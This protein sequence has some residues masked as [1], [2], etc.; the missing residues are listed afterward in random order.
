MV[1]RSLIGSHIGRT[2]GT[3]FTGPQRRN[4][5]GMTAMVSRRGLL[6]A[7]AA[8]SGVLAASPALAGPAAEQ[9]LNKLMERLW[10]EQLHRFPELATRCGA[11][12]GAQ[13]ALRGRLGPWSRAGR[14]DWVGWARSAVRRIA[15]IDATALPQAAALNRGVLLDLFSKIVAMGER[16]RFGAG[17]GDI[18]APVGPYALSP[19]AGPGQVL[20]L[21]LYAD[22]PIATTTDCEAWL[23][24]LSAVPGALDAATEAFRGDVAAGVVPPQFALDATIAQLRRL[25]G[26]DPANGPFVA[27]PA[28]RAAAA[29]LAPKWAGRAAMIVARAIGP[30]VDRQLAALAATREVAGTEAG[31]WALPQGEQFYADALA[32]HTGTALSPADVHTAGLEQVERTNAEL[33]AALAGIG[34]AS[35]TVT[36]RLAVLGENAA[37]R[38]AGGTAGQE[39][40]LATVAV[41]LRRL[42]QHLPEW[43]PILPDTPL[44]ARSMPEGYGLDQPLLAASGDGS[45]TSGSGSLLVDLGT[46]ARWPRFAIPS[47][48][49]RSAVGAGWDTAMARAS[50]DAPAIRAGGTRY[51]AFGAGWAL[52]SEQV[53]DEQ[54]YYAASPGGRIGYLQAQLL[55]AARLVADTGLHTRRW[56]HERTVSYLVE[57]T[58]LSP[59]DARAEAQRCA[60]APGEACAAA[61]GQAE[62]HRLRALARRLAGTGFDPDRFHRLIRYGPMPFGVLEDLVT[63]TFTR[64]MSVLAMRTA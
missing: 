21:L 5:S 63:T 45:F 24:R 38:F 12:T 64:R 9:Q 61:V 2:Q 42:R 26:T 8:L 51:D 23:A 49:F 54:G 30:A 19:L 62:W 11:D 53:A 16:H 13:A 22:Q 34:P 58:G 17:P 60:I 44:D 52:Y 50:A 31:A 28:A 29:G 7:A 37:Q 25:R 48:V 27:G 6:G 32:W 15:A 36:A 3:E 56:G 10:D 46:V 40:V 33:H 18:A 20:P 59:S 35:G 14:D 4:H 43:L 55:R 47:A 1:C 57:A 39:V 41:E